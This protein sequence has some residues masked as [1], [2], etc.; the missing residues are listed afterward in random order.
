MTPREKVLREVAVKFPNH[1]PTGDDNDFIC[2]ECGSSVLV[3]MENDW[4]DGDVCWTCADTALAN[5]EAFVNSELAALADADAIPDAPV[6]DEICDGCGVRRSY[7]G[8]NGGDFT[9]E[10]SCSKFL[11]PSNEPKPAPSR[12]ELIELIRGAVAAKFV[13]EEDDAGR[14]LDALVKAGAVRT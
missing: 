13:S 6:V 7:H 8:G 11:P 5:V 9:D 1:E 10:R 4:S 14:I 2:A 12:A 3:D